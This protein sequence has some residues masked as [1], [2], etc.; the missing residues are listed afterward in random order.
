MELS[1]D[2][3]PSQTTPTATAKHITQAVPTTTPTNAEVPPLPPKGKDNV[4]NNRKKSITWDHFEKVDIGKGHFK[5]VYNYCQ[6]TYLADSKGHNT[7]N[8]LNHTPIC[9]KNPNRKTLKGQ[10][11]LAFEP[12]MDGEERSKLVPTAFTVEASRKALAEMIIIDKLPFRFVERY[13][14]QIYSSTL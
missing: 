9:V 3:P 6:K 11:T 2:A 13:G 8:L 5:V 14:F 1:S 7:A 10:Q 4:C 12:K